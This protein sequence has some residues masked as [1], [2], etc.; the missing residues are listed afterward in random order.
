MSRKGKNKNSKQ[1]EP[2]FVDVKDYL[3]QQMKQLRSYCIKE[4][5]DFMVGVITN[6][7]DWIFT[8]YDM[9]AEFKIGED[10]FKE[11][12]DKNRNHEFEH[13]S[14]FKIFEINEETGHIEFNDNHFRIVLGLLQ[15]FQVYYAGIE[16]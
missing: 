14:T 7:R 15:N 3:I 2:I 13:S 12:K 5:K 11:Q 10:H 16:K 4:K 1:R 9:Q 6:S 8:R